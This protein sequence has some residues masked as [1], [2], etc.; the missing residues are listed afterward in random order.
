[1]KI[2]GIAFA[3]SAA[4]SVAACSGSPSTTATSAPPTIVTPAPV[5]A[6]VPTN[7]KGE[8]GVGTSIIGYRVNRATGA[9]TKAAVLPL[10]T[11]HQP[12]DLLVDRHGRFAYLTMLNADW[13]SVFAIDR[14][15]GALKASSTIAQKGAGADDMALAP[16][17]GYLYL[18]DMTFGKICVFR[19]DAKNGALAPAR[20]QP[21]QTSAFGATTI[22]GA[23]TF[24]YGSNEAGTQTAV[25]A[26]DRTTGALRPV[27]APV[28]SG[29]AVL[30]DPTGKYAFVNSVNSSTRYARDQHSGAL[31]GAGAT[32]PSI[33]VFDDSA[34]FAWGFDAGLYPA[35]SGITAYAFD[36]ANG[37]L[38]RAGHVAFPAGTQY[39]GCL[40]YFEGRLYAQSTR[41]SDGASTASTYSVD[42][43]SGRLKLVSSTAAGY[44]AECV[45]FANGQ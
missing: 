44:N 40:T 8:A 39:P 5:F 3:V 9:L 13:V 34:T 29:G 17:G 26:I 25:F 37:V 12:N 20:D 19:I 23:G 18:S 6:Y 27:G 30:L 16:S 22:D 4:A 41:A 10:P 42:E 7:G 45:A 38:T 31:R 15:T 33:N 2:A 24:A 1:M 14:T 35:L 11:G 32:V 36:S 43:K 21:C 28:P